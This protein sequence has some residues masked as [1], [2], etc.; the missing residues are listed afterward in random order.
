M[1]A[2]ECTRWVM[3]GRGEPCVAETGPVPDPA[4]GE[5]VIQVAG[6]GVCHTDISFLHMGVPTRTE[7]PL[8]LGHEISGTVTA[9]GSGVDDALLGRPV[10]V[11]A[12]LPCGECDLCKADRKSVV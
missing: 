10:L 12:V 8:A 6:C 7:L 5:A 1:S 4:E 11:P 2:P 3:T 9:V